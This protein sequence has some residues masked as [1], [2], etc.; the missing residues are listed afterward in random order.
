V[1]LLQK[2][3]VRCV[4]SLYHN[5][6]I[7]AMALVTTAAIAAHDLSEATLT[8]HPSDVADDQSSPDQSGHR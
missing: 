1:T 2:F 8:D 4:Q 5:R 3:C 6:W 7:G